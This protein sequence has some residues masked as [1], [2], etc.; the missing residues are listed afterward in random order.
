MSDKQSLIRAVDTIP[1]E[2]TW[3]EITDALL[4]LVARRGSVS[5][6]AR[7]YRTQLTAQQLAEYLDPRCEF[8]LDDVVA[9]LETSPASRE[10]A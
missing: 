10:T 5:D 4:D 2:A 9:E 3:A 8:P 1:D 6:F 7:L